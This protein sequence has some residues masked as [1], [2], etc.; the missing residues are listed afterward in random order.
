MSAELSICAAPLAA[1]FYRC[2]AFWAKFHFRLPF[3]VKFTATMSFGEILP[4]LG[5]PRHS[6][7]FGY[8]VLLGKISLPPAFRGE[9]YRRH[10]F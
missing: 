10:L 2:H 4:N 8:R 6:A 1:K 5:F 3:G 7:D 9:I